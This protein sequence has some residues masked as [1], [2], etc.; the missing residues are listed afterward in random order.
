M[1]SSISRTSATTVSSPVM[2]PTTPTALSFNLA[3][4]VLFGTNAPLKTIFTGPRG[5]FKTWAEAKL[6]ST[7]LIYDAQVRRYWVYGQPLDC[8]I[9]CYPPQFPTS[10]RWLLAILWSPDTC[11]LITSPLRPGTRALA[12]CSL[13]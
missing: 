11:P 4:A 3:T 10:H 8:I 7:A 9:S 6:L 1:A 12:G 13:K 5:Y 2:S